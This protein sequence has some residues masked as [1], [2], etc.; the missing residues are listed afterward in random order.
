M[1]ATFFGSRSL[2]VQSVAL[3]TGGSATLLGNGPPVCF[4]SGL[5]GLM[6]RQLYNDLFLTLSKNM[7]LV[8]LDKIAPMTRNN[9]EDIAESIGV[10]RVGF[11]AHSSFDYEILESHRINRIALCDP[12]V[13]PNSVISFDAFTTRVI[14]NHFPALVIKARDA[15]ASKAEL[16][17]PS[18]LCPT[19]TGG[20]EEVWCDGVGH[21]DLL[22][23]TWADVGARVFPWMKS[24]RPEMQPFTSWRTIPDRG[25]RDK[26]AR[27]AYRDEVAQRV[28]T[29]FLAL[30]NQKMLSDEIVVDT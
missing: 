10:D 5:Y 25:G 3:S 4:S 21:A 22:D 11:L 24:A 29:H 8:V 9:V 15:H 12:I 19:F 30:T 16:A 26:H 13:I 6:P 20:Y 14:E 23:D 7:T 2:S 28:I 27:K 18:Y 17:I 1:L